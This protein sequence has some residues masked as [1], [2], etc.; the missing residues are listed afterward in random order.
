M[1]KHLSQNEMQEARELIHEY[2]DEK[3]DIHQKIESLNVTIDWAV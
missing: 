2:A 1:R 3:G